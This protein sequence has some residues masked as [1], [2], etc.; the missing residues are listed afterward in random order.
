[1]KRAGFTM[2]ELIF[3]IVILG[4]L[5]AVAIPKLAATRS[6]AQVSKLATNI[7]TAQSEVGSYVVASGNVDFSTGAPVFEAASNVLT[8]MIA[9]GDV[10]VSNDTVTFTDGQDTSADCVTLQVDDSNVSN[11]QIVT[12]HAAGASAICLGV[13]GI[14]EE[15]N[16]SIAGNRVTY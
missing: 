7:A 1:M 16:S 4:I 14:V 6:D 5:A 10:T 11:V 8:N 12:A 3:V 9:S 13:Q 2:I 15:G